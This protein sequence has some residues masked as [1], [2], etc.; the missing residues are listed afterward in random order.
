ML[1]FEWI[2]DQHICPKPS[3]VEEHL[4]VC[5]LT[6]YQ[7]TFSISDSITKLQ[8]DGLS[9]AFF[10][11]GLSSYDRDILSKVKITDSN[12]LPTYSKLNNLQNKMV[13]FLSN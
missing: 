6:N 4:Q 13:E 8:P 9:F 10:D 2:N 11:L 1:D 12:T 3:L 7:A 5:S